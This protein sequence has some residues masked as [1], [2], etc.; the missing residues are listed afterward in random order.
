MDVNRWGPGHVPTPLLKVGVL[1]PHFFQNPDE[2]LGKH[3]IL[4]LVI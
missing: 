4:Y 3:L 2:I 1:S